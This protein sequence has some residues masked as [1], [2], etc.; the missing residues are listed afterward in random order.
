[1]PQSYSDKM[2]GLA[3]R[4][5]LDSIHGALTED[6]LRQSITKF[7]TLRNCCGKAMSRCFSASP[8]MFA[9]PLCPNRSQVMEPTANA[10]KAVEKTDMAAKK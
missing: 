8:P 6:D 7:K 10:A 1:M 4:I 2:N 3:K 9:F 5:F